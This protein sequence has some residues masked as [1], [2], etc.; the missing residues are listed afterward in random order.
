MFRAFSGVGTERAR[1]FSS[2]RD[3]SLSLSLFLPA[4]LHHF[5]TF[6]SVFVCTDVHVCEGEINN[7]PPF[8]AVSQRTLWRVFRVRSCTRLTSPASTQVEVFP[9]RFR[10]SVHREML[11]DSPRRDIREIGYKSRK[12]NRSLDDRSR[13]T[14]ESPRESRSRY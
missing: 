6:L 4:S 7:T 12:E 1:K 11:P 3:A 9:I 10:V 2:G 8:K 13:I 14:G 5:S